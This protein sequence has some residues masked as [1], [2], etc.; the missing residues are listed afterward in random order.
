MTITSLIDVIFLLLLFF[1]LAST[2]SK[3]SEVDVEIAAPGNA[4]SA[5][6]DQTLH[7]LLV[8]PGR[9]VLDGEAVA[10]SDIVSALSQVSGAGEP[11]ALTVRVNDTA[12]TQRLMDVLQM[13]SDA[14]GIVIR[15]EASPA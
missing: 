14:E 10:D 6:P 8:E 9:V 12:T 5:Q 1:M 7:T 2:F 15:L 3:F 4:S 13:L 11:T